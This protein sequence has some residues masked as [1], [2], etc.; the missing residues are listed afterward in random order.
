[1][2]VKVGI[3]IYQSNALFKGYRCPSINFNFINGT[4]CNLQKK[5]QHINSSTIPDRLDNSRCRK[6]G[7]SSYSLSGDIIIALW[8]TVFGAA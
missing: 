8:Y 3:A 6:H 1:M 5:V 4:L 2:R 7:P